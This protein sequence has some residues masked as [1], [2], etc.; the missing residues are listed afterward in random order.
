MANQHMERCSSLGKCQ[1]K[2][3]WDMVKIKNSN[4]PHAGNV[5]KVEYSHILSGDIKRLGHWRAWQILT[6]LSMQVTAQSWI[7]TNNKKE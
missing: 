1:L 5:E 6:E 7:T 2:S 3:Q 4:K